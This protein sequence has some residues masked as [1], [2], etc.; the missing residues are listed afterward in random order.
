MQARQSSRIRCSSVLLLL[1]LLFTFF[2]LLSFLLS[3]SFAQLPTLFPPGKGPFRFARLPSNLYSYR[4]DSVA[5]L[6]LYSFP[7]FKPIHCV[8]WVIFFWACLKTERLRWGSPTAT[9]PFKTFLV[10]KIVRDFSL[11][12]PSVAN[13]SAASVFFRVS[14]SAFSVKFR[15]LPWP[16]LYLALFPSVAKPIRFAKHPILSK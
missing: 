2:L 7:A 8:G 6:F 15:V 11:V 14:A 12:L 16:M 9:A 10:I 1:G 13:A 4:F 3:F 5:S